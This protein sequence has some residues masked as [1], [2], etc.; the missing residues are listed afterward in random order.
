MS[1]EHKYTFPDTNIFLHFQ[2]FTEIDWAEE[3][4]AK[5][6]TLV[7]PP[8]VGKELD[9]HKYNH[10]SERVK[11]RA[12]KV[13][14]KF[15]ELLRSKDDVRPKVKI[16]FERIEPQS[17][18]EKYHLSKD[19]QD[20][21]LIASILRFQNETGNSAILITNDFSLTLKAH[22]LNIEVFELSEK[23]QIK[24]EENPDKKKIKK[25]ESEVAELKSKIPKLQLISEDGKREITVKPLSNETFPQEEIENEV[26]LIKSKYPKI[27][28]TYKPERQIKFTIGGKPYP[29]DKVEFKFPSG[30]TMQASLSRVEKYNEELEKF[31][32]N[33][34]K[35]LNEKKRI[36]NL[37]SRTVKLQIKLTNLGTSPANAV[38]VTITFP[39]SFQITIDED[40]FS[41]PTKIHPPRLIAM[42]DIF[43]QNLGVSNY[44]SS[45]PSLLKSVLARPKLEWEK[46]FIEKNDSIYS[47]KFQNMKLSHGYTMKCPETI[48]VIF[49][50]NNQ[51]KPFQVKYKITA[52]N[53]PMPSEGKINILIEK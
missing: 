9:K 52:D 16:E 17:E 11:D 53:L 51:I 29:S 39:K 3:L 2:F 5:S 14:K 7:I 44:D 47:A 1:K 40:L 22:Q 21:H 35:Y 50:E 15:A 24:P 25:L 36:T 4:E 48:Y 46:V 42:S 8:I 13:T 41:Y 12:T 6:V 20:D 38:R 30:E 31:Y 23:Y 37:I 18:F 10:S 26:D 34:E 45:Y 19:S 32:K 28:E 33:Y 27:I 49:P 43:S